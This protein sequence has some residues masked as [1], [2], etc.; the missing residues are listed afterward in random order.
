MMHTP[1]VLTIAG[2][3]PY[4][5]AG[6]T[7]DTKTI[8]AL[9]GYALSAITAMTAQNSQGVSFVQAVEPEILR[10]QIETLLDDIHIDAVKIGMLA[11]AK[12][13]EVVA[14]AIKRYKLHR[15]VI[16]TV[17]V[18]SSG[19]ALFESNALNKMIR[20]LFPLACL[21]TPN[22]DEANKILH[23]HYTG[24]SYN[25]IEKILHHL[26]S[27]GAKNILLK[28]GHII[29]DQATDYLYSH[30]QVYHYPAPWINT[31]H[32]H[33]TGCVLS[34]AIATNLATGQSLTSSIRNAKKFLHTSLK[35]SEALH[36]RYSSVATSRKE[37]IRTLSDFSL[38]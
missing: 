36:L 2:F 29:Q 38:K 9:G 14:E 20:D 21:V 16:D 33:G 5:G 28:G 10:A 19:K 37:P 35:N 30:H 3:D 31:T 32:I 24:S 18:S 12:I 23:A 1:T 7:A 22:L 4:G 11:N 26:S 15:I 17:L 34:S 13:V 25:D 8:H 6:I 27:M